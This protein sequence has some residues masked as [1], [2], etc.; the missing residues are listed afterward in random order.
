M[1]TAV[2]A[3]SPARVVS[4]KLFR[5]WKPSAQISSSLLSVAAPAFRCRPWIVAPLAA[6]RWFAPKSVC[7]PDT[8][9]A[10]KSRA[11]AAVSIGV[12]SART[13]CRVRFGLSM[14]RPPADSECGA[15][16]LLST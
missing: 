2:V 5:T 3:T 12:P 13:P 10:P 7:A 4:T 16:T 11:P 6:T 8:M 9:V 14:N 15:G 1:V